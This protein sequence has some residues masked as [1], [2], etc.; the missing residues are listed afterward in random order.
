[1]K[2]NKTFKKI[3]LVIMALAVFLTPI[4]V[5]AETHCTNNNNHSSS[6]GNLGSWY[7]NKSEIEKHWNTVRN[8]L[9]EEYNKGNIT[10]EEYISKVP[11]GYE[12]WSCS[13]C[14]KLTGNFK[15]R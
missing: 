6:C 13:Y 9:I 15:Y 2:G 12:C 7:N 8:E 10:W 5:M 4:T 11:S 14:G 3:L 1:M